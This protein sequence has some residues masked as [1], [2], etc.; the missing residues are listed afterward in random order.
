[1]KFKNKLLLGKAEA[2][3]G[4]AENLNGADAVQTKNLEIT[5]YSGNKTSRDLD[6]DGFG[7]EAK[8]NTNPYSEITFEVELTGS[9][10]AGSAPAFAPFLK[11]CSFVE[12]IDAGVSV[13]YTLNS[14]SE[15]AATF[16]YL[17]RVSG[18]KYQLHKL[19]GCR[20][21]VAFTVDASGIP[22]MQFRFMGSYE[23]PENATVTNVN[24]SAYIDPL[25]V[26][27]ENTDVSLGAF[28]AN[29]SA[30]SLDVANSVSMRA[31]TETRD[32]NV[33]DRDP[34]ISVTLD[35]PDL[36]DF[37]VFALVESHNGITKVDTTLT[38]G[39]LAG[40]IVTI[41]AKGA[42]FSDISFT[43]SDGQLAYQ[44]S[45]SPLSDVADDE[46]ELTFA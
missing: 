29:A 24:K 28:K 18:D 2:A 10:T 15:Q 31:L 46:L 36:D 23:R 37:D 14:N 6:R 21:S 4:T 26:S 44:L 38:H 27:P 8:Q 12:V 7:A 3:P 33:S 20:G 35:A 32:V 41:R 45:G 9:G 16:G 34:T 1:M 22:V 5:P 17:Q 19:S 30:F 42:Q 40:N 25:Y 11:A 43:D 13:K 39:T